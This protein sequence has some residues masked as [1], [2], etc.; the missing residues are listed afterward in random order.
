MPDTGPAI[1]PRLNAHRPDLADARLRGRVEAARWVDGA[2]AQVAVG[3][4]PLRRAPDPGARMD[5]EVLAGERLLVFDRAD[6]WAWVQSQDDGY[7][8]YTPEEALV[9]EV[10]ALTHRVSAL[11]SFV[12]PEP[13]LKAPP[14]DALPQT[15]GVSVVGEADKF[16]EIATG[17]FVFTAHLEAPDAVAEN[18]VAEALRYLGVPYLWGG[19]T[20]LGLDCSGLTQLALRRCGIE[21]PRDADMQERAIE[22]VV[23]FDGA[24]GD[25]APGDLM[26]WPG[27]VGMMISADRIVH[28]NATD[29]M[30]S[31]WY[32]GALIAHV[33]RIEG[34]GVT[35]VRRPAYPRG[36]A[37]VTPA[38]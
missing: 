30:V 7:V 2:T 12:F 22:T 3:A 15:A 28:A 29:M 9:S 19:K 1:D 5:T 13:D 11:R 32:V 25:L 27:H 10:R 18:P 21:A 23:P 35:S 4:S 31:V 20:G 14:R 38:G 33:K 16:S 8:G 37:A 6:G 17:G 24:H 34:N 26:F 36:A